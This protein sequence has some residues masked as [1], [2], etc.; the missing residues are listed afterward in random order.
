MKSFVRLLFCAQ[1]MRPERGRPARS[2][3]AIEVEALEPRTLNTVFTQAVGSWGPRESLNAWKRGPLSQLSFLIGRWNASVKFPNGA[4]G[5]EREIVNYYFN[6]AHNEILTKQ[7]VLG[8]PRVYVSGI[9]TA[10]PATGQVV[11]TASDSA[12]RSV[13][14]LWTPTIRGS[15]VITDIYQNT[16]QELQVSTTLSRYIY[17]REVTYPDGSTQVEAIGSQI[18][19]S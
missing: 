19:V 5:A 18:R 3:K 10:D 9:L 2:T 13:V 15:F 4:T 12:G 14:Q 16:D 6:R 7:V 11:E 8:R 17:A 1:A